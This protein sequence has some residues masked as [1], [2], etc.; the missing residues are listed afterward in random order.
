MAAMILGVVLTVLALVALYVLDTA[1]GTKHR[2]FLPARWWS[3]SGLVGDS[4]G[5]GGGPPLGLGELLIYFVGSTGASG[6]V[7]VYEQTGAPSSPQVGQIWIDTD[8]APALGVGGPIYTSLPVSP[9]DGQEIR[10][11]ADAANGVVWNLRYRAASA[12]IYKWEF[13]G[14]S[15]LYAETVTNQNFA[16]FS[17]NAWGSIPNDP[18]ITVPLA[19]DYIVSLDSNMQPALTAT[20]WMGV[21]VGAVEPT[22]TMTT[23]TP[24][25]VYAYWPSTMQTG[26]QTMTLKRKLTALAAATTLT[27]REYHNGASAQSLTNGPKSMEVQ[28]VRVG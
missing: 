2:R 27:M 21:R 17:P 8:D 3:V 22:I 20:V 19:G 12:S 4:L 25:S 16:S 7:T 5:P 28:P 13:V 10:F 11:L 24:N 18:A 26:G 9:G 14:G 1:D 23:G 6:T 15:A